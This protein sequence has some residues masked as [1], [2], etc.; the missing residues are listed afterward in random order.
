MQS[1]NFLI[2]GSVL[3]SVYLY[4]TFKDL[5]TPLLEKRLKR[6]NFLITHDMLLNNL[7][8]VTDKICKDLNINNIIV[9][10][11]K[12]T[13]FNEASKTLYD[14]LN[15]FEKNKISVFFEMDYKIY[16][17]KELFWNSVR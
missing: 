3:D 16:N 7:N 8:S 10:N 4:A 6:V 5:N 15:S 11:D 13:Y 2:S 9:Q 17:N 1:K 14:S 12:N